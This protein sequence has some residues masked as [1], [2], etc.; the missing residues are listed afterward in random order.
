M[1]EA[2]S[3]QR[4][5]SESSRLRSDGPLASPA[6]AIFQ[7]RL[8]A[9]AG[10]N[11]AYAT[12]LGDPYSDGI[13]A[14]ASAEGVAT[15]LILRVPGRR[16]GLCLID[17]DA[18]GKRHFT[19]GGRKRPGVSF[20]LPDWARGRRQLASGAHDLFLRRDASPIPIPDLAAGGCRLARQQYQI[21]L[22]GNFR[23]TAG[24]APAFRTRAVF[25]EGLKRVDIALPTMT[26]G[27]V[28]GDQARG[29]VDRLQ[30]FASARLSSKRTHSALV[31]TSGEREF[32]PVPQ[33]VEP[34]D[35]TAVGDSFNAGYLAARLSNEGPLTAAAA[36]HRLAGEKIR[37]H[38][39]I[40]PR[41]DAR[42]H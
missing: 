21:T 13:L 31:A 28:W 36:A 35:A 19:I 26:T 12:A 37:H 1:N 14:L 24:R 9:R 18:G 5:R 15:G 34:V 32:V 29:P 38:G 8:S 2:K 4:R 10:I 42:V 30:A 23:P 7:R 3:R 17:N 22:D 40:M 20:R 16:P 11:V 39:A 41:A 27:R 6:A 33:V 25:L